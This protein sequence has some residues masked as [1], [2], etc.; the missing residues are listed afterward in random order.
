MNKYLWLGLLSVISS[1]VLANPGFAPWTEVMI[2]ADKN[3]DKKL[4]PNEIMYFE[5]RD[6]YTGFQPFMVDHFPKFDF[7]G[8][9][10]LSFEECK[11]GMQMAGYSDEEVMTQY[12]RDFGFRPWDSKKGH[13]KHNHQDM[14]N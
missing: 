5:Q 12:K 6:H 1:S 11:K 13:Q 4:S 10:L 7:D 9:G 8:D 2:L 14:K 3:D